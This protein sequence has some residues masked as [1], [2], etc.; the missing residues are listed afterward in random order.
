MTLYAWR[1]LQDG[2]YASGRIEAIN[3]DEAAFKVKEQKVIITSLVRVSGSDEKKETKGSKRLQSCALCRF[4][5][6]KGWLPLHAVHHA[7]MRLHWGY[8]YW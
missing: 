3:R 5:A 7:D 6:L 8:S 4:T 1:G 2:K